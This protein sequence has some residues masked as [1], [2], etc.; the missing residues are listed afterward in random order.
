MSPW[1]RAP[2][3]VLTNRERYTLTH[4]A[5][6]RFAAA[7]GTVIIWWM[8]SWSHW[9]QKPPEV[10]L[11]E[12]LLDPCFYEYWVFDADASLT[13]RLCMYICLVNAQSVWCHSLTLVT[14]EEQQELQQRITTSEP[15]SVIT[16]AH[17]PLAI[18]MKLGT[19][20]FTQEQ[21]QHL[22]QFRLDVSTEDMT[23]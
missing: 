3:I 10:F 20:K 14:S 18:N 1:F 8:T 12:A 5:A 11:E 13:A 6:V 4:D 22:Q 16:L 9:A 15:G 21:L 7:T 23:I 2:I 19:K 17:A